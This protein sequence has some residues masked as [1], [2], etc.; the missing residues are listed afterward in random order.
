[1][2]SLKT[3]TKHSWILV[4]VVLSSG[5]LWSQIVG[6]AISKVLSGRASSANLWRSNESLNVSFV[7]LLPVNISS[8]NIP[9][10]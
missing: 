3:E 10:L 6:S 8:S 9:R 5:S 4:L 1:M 7:G 2:P